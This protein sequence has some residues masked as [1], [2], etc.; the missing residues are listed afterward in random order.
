MYYAN[1]Q[2]TYLYVYEAKTG[3]PHFTIGIRDTLTS[4]NVN[5]NTLTVCYNNGQVEV[6]DLPSRARLR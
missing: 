1:V 5:G 2:G 3:A 6:Y 4:F